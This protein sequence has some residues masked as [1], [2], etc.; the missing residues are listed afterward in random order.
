MMFSKQKV[1]ERIRVVE[2]CSIGISLMES[3]T[4]LCTIYKEEFSGANEFGDFVASSNA[5]V[6][7]LF[8]WKFKKAFLFL[9]KGVMVMESSYLKLYSDLLSRVCLV[10]VKIIFVENNFSILRCLA[11]KKRKIIFRGKWFSPIWRKIFSS[12][13]LRKLI[14]L[15]NPQVARHVHLP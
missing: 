6:W 15:S 7:P 8:V 3:L 10:G 9:F 5:L 4:S 2:C 11:K 13:K 14:F 1:G 12:K